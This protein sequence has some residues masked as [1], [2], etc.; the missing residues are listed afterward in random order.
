[1][2]FGQG[3][4]ATETCALATTTFKGQMVQDY[5][6]S[7]ELMPNVEMKFIDPATG[8]DLPIGQVSTVTRNCLIK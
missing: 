3:Y 8:E 4:G 6:A 7:G 1:M 2:E 5:S